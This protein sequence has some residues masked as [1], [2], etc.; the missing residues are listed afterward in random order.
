MKE[1][2]KLIESNKYQINIKHEELVF[3]LNQHTK[4]IFNEHNTYSFI[5]M[6][7]LKYEQIQN[8]YFIEKNLNILFSVEKIKREYTYFTW[9]IKEKNMNFSEEKNLV[10]NIVNNL[11]QHMIRLFLDISIPFIIENIYLN[12]ENKTKKW[13]DYQYLNSKTNFDFKNEKNIQKI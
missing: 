9:E 13:L 12:I 8:D 1:I 4:N 10:K 7:M 5:N 6:F 2:F 3:L 11:P